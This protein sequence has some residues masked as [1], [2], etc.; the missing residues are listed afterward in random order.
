MVLEGVKN[1]TE[2]SP[3]QTIVD[4]HA[5]PAANTAKNMAIRSVRK[6]MRSEKQKC[7]GRLLMMLNFVFNFASVRILFCDS[8]IYRY[9]GN[10]MTSEHSYA[11]EKERRTILH[12]RRVGVGPSDAAFLTRQAYAWEL[13]FFRVL[14]GLSVRFAPVRGGLRPGETCRRPASA[15][16]RAQFMSGSCFPCGNSR[17][18]GVY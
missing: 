2:E 17:P 9:G 4:A 1:R 15:A 12:K 18:D 6:K 13:Y 5:A 8:D 14:R 11:F 3:I 10:F 7:A 16:G